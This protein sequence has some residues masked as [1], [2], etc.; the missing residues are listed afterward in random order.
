MAPFSLEN[1]FILAAWS[2]FLVQ[3]GSL[4][5][6]TV[7][8]PEMSTV[9]TTEPLFPGPFPLTLQVCVSPGLDE[10]KL[11]SY[12]YTT[13]DHDSFYTYYFGFKSLSGTSKIGWGG[14]NAIGSFEDPAGDNCSKSII[15][16]L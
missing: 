5:Y 10:D 8:H 2:F 13:G 6:N 1:V 12:G 9:L 7:Y 16:A 15:S 11:R 4:T 14:L 3:L